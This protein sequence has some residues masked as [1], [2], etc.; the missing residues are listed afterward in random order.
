M[1]EITKRGLYCPLGDFYIDPWNP[2][3]TALI[4]HAHG[5]HARYGHSH[6]IIE[7]NSKEILQYRL[8]QEAS[9]QTVKYGEK[10]KFGTVWVSFHSAG[11]ILGSS[12][13]RIQSPS[14]VVVV[15]GD[16]KRDYDPSCHPFEQLECDLF[17]TEST[18][19]L[20]IY[21]WKDPK[22][23]AHEIYQWWQDNAL[24]GRPS[25]LFCYALGKA[26]RILALLREITDQ[27]AFIHG[28]IAPFNQFYERQGIPL[29]KTR[30]VTQLEKDQDYSKSLILAPTSAF[31]SLW[32]RRF[33]QP[34]T[35]FAS[36][37]MAVRGT[38][39]RQGYDKGF[40]LSDHADWESLNQTILATRA[41]TIWVTH[42]ETEIL[43][44][45]LQ[46]KHNLDAKPLPGFISE[47]ED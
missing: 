41:K 31:R 40:V 9:I 5:D 6:S 15:S 32:M 37:W 45:Y 23:V 13:I 11:H 26:Q 24:E 4:T 16:Y 30:V 28:A 19:G 8:G 42:G 35:A 20:P 14:Q 17:V 46:E 25:L 47:E 33:K 29:L 3:S 36:G 44:R 7:E 27:E 34:R 21:R 43:S 1:L 12:Q 39:R 22:K 10:R 38:K 2:V 18:F